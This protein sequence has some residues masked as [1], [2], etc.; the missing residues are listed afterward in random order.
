V[1]ANVNRSGPLVVRLGQVLSADH[2]YVADKPVDDY[3]GDPV[4]HGSVDFEFNVCP[5]QGE[6]V[7]GH[8]SN[9]PKKANGHPQHVE[10][11]YL[12]KP[13]QRKGGQ[14]LWLPDFALLVGRYEAC[15][16]GE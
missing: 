3:T 10:E 2:L 14:T 4:F 8:H 12:H 5:T 15:H 11:E 9:A 13:V 7:A 6:N 1:I 16:D